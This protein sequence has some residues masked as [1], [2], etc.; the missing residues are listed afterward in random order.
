M[1]NDQFVDQQWKAKMMMM[2]MKMMGVGAYDDDDDDDDDQDEEVAEL[3]SWLSPD[4]LTSIPAAAANH[5][6]FNRN[7]Q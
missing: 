1:A 7:F 5:K 6:E 3:H 4:R 2:M